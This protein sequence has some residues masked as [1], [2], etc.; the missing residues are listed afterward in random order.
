M[1]VNH[2]LVHCEA[3]A[4]AILGIVLAQAIIW[5]FFRI[6][7]QQAVLLNIVMIGVSYI[8]NY[9]MRILFMRFEYVDG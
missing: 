6:E 4:N 7:F 8:R 2:R 9:V 5:M 1:R 3:F